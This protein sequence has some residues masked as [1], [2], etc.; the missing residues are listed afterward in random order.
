MLL[1]QIKSTVIVVTLVLPTQQT[2]HINSLLWLLHN[3]DS[4]LE[5]TASMEN[6]YEMMRHVSWPSSFVQWIPIITDRCWFIYLFFFFNARLLW[7]NPYQS[8]NAN[9]KRVGGTDNGKKDIHPPNKIIENNKQPIHHSLFR[10]CLEKILPFVWAT[11][12]NAVSVL[13]QFSDK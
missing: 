4:I 3:L 6:L 13:T 11:C 2:I 5:L 1:R 8:I 7:S 9:R 10:R 12:D